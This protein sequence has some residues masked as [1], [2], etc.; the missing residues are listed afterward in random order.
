MT[1]AAARKLRDLLSSDK[2][3][4][5]SELSQA[6]FR[7]LM[8]EQ[9]VTIVQV[10]RTRKALYAHNKDAVINYLRNKKGIPDLDKYVDELEQ[11]GP[12]RADAVAVA[13]N[14]KLTR[15][16]TFE[17]FLVNSIKPIEAKLNGRLLVLPPQEGTF[18]HIYDWTGFEIPSGI[19]IV[20]VEN[21]EVFRYPRRLPDEL[22]IK[23]ALFVCRYPYSGDLVTWIS[24]HQN[25]YIHF[26]DFDWAGMN[27]YLDEYKAK[28]GVRASLLIPGNLGEKLKDGST[29]LY[30]EQFH[31]RKKLEDV[32][33]DDAIRLYELLLK[34]RK[35]I[36]Q[37]IY[38]K[39]KDVSG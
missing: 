4:P 25:P 5:L 6:I 31:L 16:R 10:G 28:L 24:R 13:T 23:E 2:P 29:K 1:L 14:S 27:I 19:K 15:K 39:E 34:N 30:N 21:G 36:E 8:E 35:V 37:E 33:D 12:L 26:G 22:N 11:P 9:V 3:V 20:G 38:L 32:K 7:E 17:G 18:I